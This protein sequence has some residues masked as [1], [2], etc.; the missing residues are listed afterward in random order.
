MDSLSEMS[1]RLGDMYDDDDGADL[2]LA[3]YVDLSMVPVPRSHIGADMAALTAAAAA[4]PHPIVVAGPLA[5]LHDHWV[6]L[7][8]LAR[9]A[10]G[11]ALG[12][13]ALTGV[14]WVL[15]A[16]GGKVALGHAAASA[17]GAALTAAPIAA[18]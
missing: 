3:N 2:V 8:P 4:P 15:G 6:A 14:A 16:A 17:C 1:T 11:L 5:M 9:V 10:I 13:A 18:L 12:A 7:P